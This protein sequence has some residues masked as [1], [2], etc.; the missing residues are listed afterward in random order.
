LI[1]PYFSELNTSV[2]KV[3][4]VLVATASLLTATEQVQAQNNGDIR[5]VN[6]N[7]ITIDISGRLEIFIDGK[8]GTICGN[9]GTDLQ[10]V[11]DTACR[12][13]GLTEASIVFGSGT[14][15]Q[16]GFPVAPKSTPIHFGSIDCG[17]SDSDDTC[18][19]DYSQHVLRCAVDAN[20]DTTACTHDEDIAINCFRSSITS[21]PYQSQVALLPVG[22][23]R[24]PPKLNLSRSS[25]GLVLDNTSKYG[26]VC[27]EGFDKSAADTAC[28]QLG[29]T[30][31]NYFNTSLQPLKQTFWDAGLNCKSQSHSCL[32]NCFSKTPT[33][34]TSCTKL[35]YLS[36]EFD[37]SHK[38]AE[39]AGSPRLCDATVDDKCKPDIEEYTITVPIIV[40]VVIIVAILAVCA[41][42]ITLCVCCFMPGC[43]IH[44]KRSGYQS[45]N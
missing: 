15:T 33:N 27:V 37:L 36:C 41:T 4:F 26:L 42:C 1:Y 17:S 32:N 9:S 14:V 8:W 44:R 29:Y 10:A 21:H 16:L 5:L 11:A 43:P 24:H 31:A 6:N 19:T 25:G 34:H 39:S 3:L 45:V 38:N 23:Q 18:S 12:Q 28:R 22:D 40:V 13:L 35:V 20:V 30:N 2:M 7:Q